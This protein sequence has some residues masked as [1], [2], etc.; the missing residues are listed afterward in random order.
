VNALYAPASSAL[1]VSRAGAGCDGA[2]RQFD[3]RAHR[4]PLQ[5]HPLRRPEDLAKVAGTAPPAWE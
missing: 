2:L 3:P 5:R 4:L 1:A